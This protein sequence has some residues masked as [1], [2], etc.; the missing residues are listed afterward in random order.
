MTDQCLKVAGEFGK[1]LAQEIPLEA[2]IPGN[3]RIYY[4]AYENTSRLASDA[5]RA[6]TEIVFEPP[7]VP[8]SSESIGLPAVPEPG[9]P[10]LPRDSAIG[11]ANTFGGYQAH[12]V[13]GGSV[14]EFGNPTGPSA[15]P[16]FNTHLSSPL[17]VTRSPY[18]PPPGPP[19]SQ[20]PSGSHF[21]TFPARHNI[22]DEVHPTRLSTESHQALIPPA[23]PQT[24]D[25]EPSFSESIADALAADG[26][27]LNGNQATPPLLQSGTSF[28]TG[29]P[30]REPEGNILPVPAA[31]SSHA[32]HRGDSEYDDV[33]EGTSL[34]YA[35]EP[36]P[37]T[38]SKKLSESLDDAYDGTSKL[39]S[40]RKVP[41]D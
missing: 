3:A 6:I 15:P 41:F 38:R 18:A 5:S 7:A 4:N 14:D 16:R 11:H 8:L 20:S 39:C 32:R 21:A 17:S 30:G 27:S 40:C 23:P 19:P 31:K 1:T 24:H 22:T 13:R 9:S 37:P 35:A 34:A 25:V 2:T 33:D 10:A 28:A 29:A 36:K 26:Y 12:G